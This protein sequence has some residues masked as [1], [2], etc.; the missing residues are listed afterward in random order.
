MSF[1]ALPPHQLLALAQ[2]L[3]A[4]PSL[5]VLDSDLPPLGIVPER[6]PVAAQDLDHMIVGDPGPENDT[7]TRLAVAV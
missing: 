5:P 3:G 2:A 7:V 4:L 1:P 6:F